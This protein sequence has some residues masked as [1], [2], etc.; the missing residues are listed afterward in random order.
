LANGKYVSTS[1]ESKVS[2]S[3]DSLLTTKDLQSLKKN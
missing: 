1:K 2:T 3:C